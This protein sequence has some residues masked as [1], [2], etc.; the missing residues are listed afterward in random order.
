LGD[1][2]AALALTE[3]FRNDWATGRWHQVRICFDEVPEQG[4]NSATMCFVSDEQ[5]TQSE[6]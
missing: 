1:L 5:E 3:R 6:A 2:T 4:I